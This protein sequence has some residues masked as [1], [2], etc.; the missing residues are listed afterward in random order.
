MPSRERPRRPHRPGRPS[1]L[2]TPN[3]ADP[4]LLPPVPVLSPLLTR[5]LNARV[6]D[7][8][9]AVLAPDE[10]KPVP[11]VYVSD[12]LLVRDVERAAAD[13][14]GEPRSRVEE[15][16]DYA[17]RLPEPMTLDVVGEPVLVPYRG[18]APHAMGPDAKVTVTRVRLGRHPERAGRSPDARRFLQGALSEPSDRAALLHDK[19][20]VGRLPEDADPA[21]EGE[22]RRRARRHRRARSM[23]GGV[24]VEHVL[25]AGGGVWGGGGGI[26]GAAAA[27][28]AAGAAS[29]AVAAASCRSTASRASADARR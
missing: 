23:A 9:A 25:T 8:E 3:D 2:V 22:R 6:L 18:D 11:T 24:S 14:A 7:P 28:G 4:T 1:D 20:G 10:P 27:S 17:G 5:R 26:W 16:A 13:D 19:L 21:D 29:G 15:L 12:T